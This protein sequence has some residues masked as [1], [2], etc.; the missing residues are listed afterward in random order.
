LPKHEHILHNHTKIGNNQYRNEDLGAI[1]AKNRETAVNHK[2]EKTQENYQTQKEAKLA[3]QVLTQNILSEYQPKSENISNSQQK[4][5][6]FG[7]GIEAE[8]KA[9][10]KKVKV[11]CWEIKVEKIKKGRGIRR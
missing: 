8:K 2:L 7:T 4:L 11:K 10:V 9:F 1:Y 6:D 5:V 3:K